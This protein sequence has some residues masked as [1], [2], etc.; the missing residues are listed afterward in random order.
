MLAAS[1]NP[2]GELP[3]IVTTLATSA[4]CSSCSVWVDA[5]A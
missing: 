2:L 5:G 3:M 1:A 4:I